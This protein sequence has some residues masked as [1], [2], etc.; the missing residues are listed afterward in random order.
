MEKIFFA[1]HSLEFIKHEVLFDAK[2]FSTFHRFS[3][4]NQLTLYNLK[5]LQQEIYTMVSFKIIIIWP[6][7]TIIGMSATI[8]LKT[9]F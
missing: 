4:F 2:V 6:S 3:P 9:D 7:Y 5:E 1:F 8:N